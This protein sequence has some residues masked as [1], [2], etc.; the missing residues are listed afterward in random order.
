MRCERCQKPAIMHITEIHSDAQYDEH[1]LCEEC[2]R[3]YQTQ[4]EPAAKPAPKPANPSGLE[5]HEEALALNERQ[6]D[7]CGIKFV[8]FRNTGRLGCPH[9]YEA[10]QSELV[11]LLE[12]IH[13]TAQHTGK[14][15]KRLPE[16]RSLLSELARLR[17]QLAEAIE[18]ERYE[19][20]AQL[21]DAIRQKEQH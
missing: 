8:D 3:T 5:E 11:P 21:R 20:A 14:K 13:G 7:H 9:D 16:T 10:F 15:P 12:S 19:T 18:Q 17:K 1:H 2:W 4:P 6:C